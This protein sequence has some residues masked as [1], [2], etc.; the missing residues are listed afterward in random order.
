MGVW[1]LATVGDSC[2]SMFGAV[3]D[4]GALV[5]PP[6]ASVLEIGCAEADWMTPMLA[7][8]PDLHITG[9]DWRACERPGTVIHDNVLA[10]PFPAASFDAVVGVS[11]IEHI[12][13]GH[14]NHDPE[15]HDGDVR[16]MRRVV[17]WLKPGGWVYADVPYGPTY[18]VEGTSHR[19]YNDEA[20][21]AR[22]MV[23]GLT[24]RRRWYTTWGDGDYVLHDR[25]AMHADRFVYVALLAMKEP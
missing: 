17:Q 19:V 13:L 4:T 18:R 16:C 3:Y 8:R 21:A 7:V 11:S 23:F 12:G 14:Y 9:I 2:I 22:L 24:E 1:P 15:D 6:N 5:F 20:I 10:Y 25:P